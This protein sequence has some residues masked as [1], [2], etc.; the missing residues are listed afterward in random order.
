MLSSNQLSHISD[1]L[2]V[3]QEKIPFLQTHKS[4]NDF[5]L[6]SFQQDLK[7]DFFDISKFDNQNSTHVELRNFFKDSVEKD[8]FINDVVF[9]E[10]NKHKAN[11]SIILQDIN[12]VVYIMIPM[13]DESGQ[14]IGFISI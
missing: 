11:M 3:F 8:I 12:P 5:L 1:V 7:I 2:N 14:V 13:F 6:R 10:E 9:I 4:L